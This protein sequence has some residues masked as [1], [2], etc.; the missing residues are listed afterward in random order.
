MKV[1]SCCKRSLSIEFFGSNR[2]TRDGKNVYCRECVR[3]KSKDRSE[4][5]R[6]WRSE[7]REKW[8]A[9]F[10]EWVAKN[11]ERRKQIV[12]MSEEKHRDKR[13]AKKREYYLANKDK[14]RYW[15][16][17][18][19]KEK[20]RATKYRYLSRKASVF[21]EPYDSRK[22]FESFNYRCVYC[23]SEATCLDHVIPISRGGPDIVANL[24]AA[25]RPCNTSKGSKMINEWFSV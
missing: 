17:L 12:K 8:N 25:C 6:Q 18:C 20:K 13:L 19:N 14:F 16:S 21:S 10:R 24:V 11:K 5:H 7:N 1:C 2:S 3:Q 9:Q 4:Y 15:Q 22:I 23:N